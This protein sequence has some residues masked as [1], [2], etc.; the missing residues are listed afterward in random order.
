M[1]RFSSKND[2]PKYCDTLPPAAKSRKLFKTFSHG[3]EVFSIVM[4]CQI[5]RSLCIENCLFSPFLGEKCKICES[6]STPSY[7][8]L[9]CFTL[10]I[11]HLE[12][13]RRCLFQVKCTAAAA[14][15]YINL[16]FTKLGKKLEF[17]VWKKRRTVCKEIVL[18]WV[19]SESPTQV[20]R[21]LMSLTTLG[22]K[23]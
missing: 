4:W 17:V 5:N 16:E 10:D 18:Q 2:L 22:V 3:C 12:F 19:F 11:K 8:G 1:C 14:I 6:R 21:K 9:W 15:T 13:S 20:L 23:A 7:N